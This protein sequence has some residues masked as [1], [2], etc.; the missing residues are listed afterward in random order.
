MN[1]LLNI[2][3]AQP[4][5]LT[6]KYYFKW[7]QA[8]DAV[9]LDLE[10]SLGEKA[11]TWA[12]GN[13]A[14]AAERFQKANSTICFRVESS[15]PH[16]AKQIDAINRLKTPVTVILPKVQTADQVRSFR[17]KLASQHQVALVVESPKAFLQ[18]EKILNTT[19]LRFVIFGIMDY[20]AHLGI[21]ASAVFFRP[22]AAQ[23]VN[24]CA[25]FDVPVFG[26]AADFTQLTG[27]Q[28]QRKY[29]ANLRLSK[30]LG[31]HGAFAV[32]A[33]QVPLIH[34]V[35]GVSGDQ[36]KKMKDFVRNYDLENPISVSQGKMI[37]PPIRKNIETRLKKY[38]TRDGV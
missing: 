35:F 38:R 24:L 29:L 11:K 17:Q 28:W 2:P 16:F 23:V 8:A 33:K 36:A 4:K 20:S 3:L 10:D 34:S 32:H 26:Y 5:I 31:F 15:A 30:R 22:I 7:A 12:C 21:A 6:S 9:I 14:T 25:A 1:S 27:D 19:A 37:G 18:L 13:I